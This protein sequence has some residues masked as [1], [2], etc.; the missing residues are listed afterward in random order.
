MSHIANLTEWFSENGRLHLT[1]HYIT[2]VYGD[3]QSHGPIDGGER[4]ELSYPIEEPYDDIKQFESDSKHQ[5]GDGLSVQGESRRYSRK[6]QFGIDY[7]DTDE[8]FDGTKETGF[9]ENNFVS[10]VT[11]QADGHMDDVPDGGYITSS[12]PASALQTVPA[13]GAHKFMKAIPPA[14]ESTKN[15]NE[16]Y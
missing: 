5:D 9:I 8:A 1:S 4:H 14:P 13:P 7:G 11:S 16:T 15:D 2:P 6:R 10:E 3:R 12:P